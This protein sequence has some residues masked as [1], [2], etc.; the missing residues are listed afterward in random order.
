LRWETGFRILASAGRR[1]PYRKATLR[2][3]K[4]VLNYR[5]GKVRLKEHRYLSGAMSLGRAFL[6]DPRRSVRVMLGMDK[7]K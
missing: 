2:K 5:I 3:R 7:S 1:Y 6:L 4:A